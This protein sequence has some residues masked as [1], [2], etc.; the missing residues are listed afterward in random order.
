MKYRIEKVT[1]EDGTCRYFPQYSFIDWRFFF[2]SALIPFMGWPLIPAALIYYR[3]HYFYYV[4]MHLEPDKR[5][6]KQKESKCKE[7]KRG[8]ELEMHLQNDGM[9][10]YNADWEHPVF[11]SDYQKAEEIVLRD[12]ERVKSSKK[13]LV[14]EKVKFIKL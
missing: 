4:S 3:W 2:L 12:K 11:Y 14:K 5:C 1:L 13:P 10:E 9:G 8:K 6:V 7:R